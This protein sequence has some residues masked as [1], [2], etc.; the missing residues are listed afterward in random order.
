MLNNTEDMLRSILISIASLMPKTV[1]GLKIVNGYH[2]SRSLLNSLSLNEVIIHFQ[3][4]REPVNAIVYTVNPIFNNMTST[5][6]T[7]MY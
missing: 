2:L 3:Y 4:T 5:C 7:A 6:I 1:G